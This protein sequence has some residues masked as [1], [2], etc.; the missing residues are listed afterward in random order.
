MWLTRPAWNRQRRFKGFDDASGKCELWICHPKGCYGM[1]L[2]NPSTESLN[3]GNFSHGTGKAICCTHLKKSIKI[4]PLIFHL[5]KIKHFQDMWHLFV[6]SFWVFTPKYLRIFRRKSSHWYQQLGGIPGPLTVDSVKFYRG[7][8]IT[9][10]RLLFH[11]LVGG[12]YHSKTCW[13]KSLPNPWRMLQKCHGAACDKVW[14][15]C[16]HEFL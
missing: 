8:F 16:D 5:Y 1:F 9:M 14:Q 15:M 4:N 12:G 3:V 11:L 6:F 2:P 13:I 10:K 7:P